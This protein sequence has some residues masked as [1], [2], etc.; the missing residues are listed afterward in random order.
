MRVLVWAATF[1]AIVGSAHSGGT[2]ASPLHPSL[3][4]EQFPDKTFEL[5]ALSNGGSSRQVE[6]TFES[7]VS[8]A[9]FS[10]SDHETLSSMTG[11][12]EGDAT[13]AAILSGSYGVTQASAIAEPGPAVALDF[14]WDAVDLMPSPAVLAGMA[15]FERRYLVGDED[16]SS[17][18]AETGTLELRGS[19]DPDETIIALDGY[20][21]R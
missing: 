7:W 21:D 20:E 14:E 12:L 5:V 15:L 18:P 17:E 8:A 1:G 9:F 10:T 16:S 6:S 3:F 11:F 19:S 13:P 2:S 4:A